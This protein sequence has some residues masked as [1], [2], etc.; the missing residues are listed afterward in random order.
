MIAALVAAVGA[1]TLAMSVAW[2]VQRRIGK[3]HEPWHFM[4]CATTASS[5][6]EIGPGLNSGDPCKVESA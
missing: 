2:R 1:L 5:A 3:Q 4:S 6:S